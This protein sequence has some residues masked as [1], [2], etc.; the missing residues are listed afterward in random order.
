MTR[1]LHPHIAACKG[2]PSYA[3]QTPNLGL[4][5]M[6]SKLREGWEAGQASNRETYKK[7]DRMQAAAQAKLE[8]ARAAYAEATKKPKKVRTCLFGYQHE[9]NGDRYLV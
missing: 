9:N 8:A 6:G 2:K 1:S 7:M 5:Y 3:S 4:S